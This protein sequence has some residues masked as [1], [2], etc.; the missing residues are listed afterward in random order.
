MSQLDS[1]KEEIKAMQEYYKRELKTLND[2]IESL[3]IKLYEV[4]HG[5]YIN[6]VK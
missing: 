2:R 4:E 3:C 6:T 5:K 1:I